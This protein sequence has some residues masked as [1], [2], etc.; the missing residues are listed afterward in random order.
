MNGVLSVAT[1][2]Y[3]KLIK[4]I[5]KTEN[6]IFPYKSMKSCAGA[7]IPLEDK[8]I[9]IPDSDLH[10]YV[11]FLDDAKDDTRASGCFCAIDTVY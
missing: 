3:S 6:N 4:V 9:G 7:E 1:Y 10:I 8:T 11:F 2:Y 5:P